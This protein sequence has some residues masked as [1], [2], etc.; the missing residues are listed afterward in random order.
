MSLFNSINHKYIVILRK[1]GLIFII[2]IWMS[3]N[4]C[5]GDKMI[6]YLFFN[7]INLI[8]YFT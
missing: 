2:N 1:R 6:T 5:L 8:H 4:G 3:E 7:L